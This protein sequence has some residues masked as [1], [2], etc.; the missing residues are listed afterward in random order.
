MAR[1]SPFSTVFNPVF[2][3]FSKSLF[4]YDDDD[5]ND[6]YN[7]TRTGFAVGLAIDGCAACAVAAPT[8]A[9]ASGSSS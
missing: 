7:P 2:T 5:D 6:H 4:R 3:V 1:L 9:S 8:S